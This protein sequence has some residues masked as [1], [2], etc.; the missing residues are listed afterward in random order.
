MEEGSSLSL[1]GCDPSWLRWTG[2]PSY[3][4]CGIRLQRTCSDN[5]QI[6]ACRHA[7]C[8]EGRGRPPLLSGHS[9]SMEHFGCRTTA[10]QDPAGRCVFLH[11]AVSVIQAHSTDMH[12]DGGEHPACLLRA[13]CCADSNLSVVKGSGSIASKSFMTVYTKNLTEQT[14][15]TY[16]NVQYT[17]DAIGDTQGDAP[18]LML[19]DMPA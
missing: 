11:L 15:P 5:P 4:D 17:Y 3:D 10:W 16:G 1:S 2:V 7:R 14:S 12:C 8:A 19:D 6:T 13:L 18:C 9:H